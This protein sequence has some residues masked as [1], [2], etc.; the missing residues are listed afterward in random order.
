[1]IATLIH[2]DYMFKLQH[3]GRPRHRLSVLIQSQQVETLVTDNSFLSHR[4][5]LDDT[6]SLCFNTTRWLLVPNETPSLD[7]EAGDLAAESTV[8]CIIELSLETVYN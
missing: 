4:K 5:N 7:V 3:S 6:H 1:M 2:S 8:I